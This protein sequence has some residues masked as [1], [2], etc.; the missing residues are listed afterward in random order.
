MQRAVYRASTALTYGIR[1][2]SITYDRACSPARP[3]KLP[4]H[5]PIPLSAHMAPVSDDM[6]INHGYWH[7]N[8][9]IMGYLNL[10]SSGWRW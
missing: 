8:M 10:T 4:T 9:V 1:E 6:G 2:H 5:D 7:V 3:R